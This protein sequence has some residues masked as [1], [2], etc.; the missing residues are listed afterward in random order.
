M[1]IILVEWIIT[2]FRI[3]WT[4][5]A[6]VHRYFT[7]NRAI[8]FDVSFPA[9]FA[10]SCGMHFNSSQITIVWIVVINN[11]FLACQALHRNLPRVWGTWLCFGFF[12]SSEAMS[13][14][15]GPGFSCHVTPFFFSLKPILYDLIFSP[16]TYENSSTL[17]TRNF[18]QTRMIME[19][20]LEQ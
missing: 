11:Q 15:H 17:F 12:S 4:L 13:E 7:F 3:I 8:S 18:Y 6:S 2:I 9:A 20:T 1:Y 14:P 16:W 19:E 10:A 5:A